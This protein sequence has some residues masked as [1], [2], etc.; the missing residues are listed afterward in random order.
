MKRLLRWFIVV[1]V[2]A[3]VSVAVFRLVNERR[4]V[5]SNVATSAVPQ[6]LDL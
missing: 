6:A 2:I 1:A 3:A 5:Q 4:Q